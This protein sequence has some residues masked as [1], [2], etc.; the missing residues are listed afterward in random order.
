MTK[1]T[2]ITPATKRPRKMAREPQM[3]SVGEGAAGAYPAGAAGASDAAETP[4]ANKA[5]TKAAIVLDLL[6]RPEGAS[7]EQLVAATGWLPHTTRAA[8]TGLRKKG[9]AVTSDKPEGAARAYRLA[10]PEA[11]G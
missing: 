10:A 6:R 7:I 5:Q 3:E 1:S 8:L 11:A 2:D 4:S 9:H